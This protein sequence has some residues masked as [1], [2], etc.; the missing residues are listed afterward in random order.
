MSRPVVASTLVT[1]VLLA[2]SPVVSADVTQYEWSPV[3]GAA[4]YQGNVSDGGATRT[5]RT[6][7]TWV[8]FDEASDVTAH[9][10]GADGR[11]IAPVSLK[12]QSRLPPQQ[13]LPPPDSVPQSAPLAETE[14]AAPLDD[15]FTDDDDDDDVVVTPEPPTEPMATTSEDAD[16]RRIENAHVTLQLGIGK[17]WLKANGG[18][19]EYDGNSNVGGTIVSGSIGATTSP[20]TYPFLIEAHNFSTKVNE[21]NATSG[22]SESQDKFLRLAVRAGGDY[23]LFHTGTGPGAHGLSVLAGIAYVRLPVLA[24]TNDLTGVA[25]LENTAAFGPYLGVGYTRYF[26][27]E[28]IAGIG[29]QTVP[30]SLAKD[31]KAL[32]TSAL[33]YW[34]HALAARLYMELGFAHDTT[35]FDTTFDCPNVSGCESASHSS[36]RLIQGRLGVGAR[37]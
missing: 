7:S 24:S 13:P 9:A 3:S 21:Q 1:G 16:M 29:V 12:K 15:D 20:W 36:D 23:D 19:S 5:F 22:A 26:D 4:F 17:E 6:Q 30:V 2:V 8:L 28:N 32:S 37:F 27:A 25:T 35:S 34:R 14:P 33:L 31:V 18:V 11:V 10:Y